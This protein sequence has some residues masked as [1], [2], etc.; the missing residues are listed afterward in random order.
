MMQVSNTMHMGRRKLMPNHKKIIK[1]FKKINQ[2]YK[3][4]HG[5]WDNWVTTHLVIIFDHEIRVIQTNILVHD[6]E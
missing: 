2:V 4:G 5:D 3:M 6:G 1:V